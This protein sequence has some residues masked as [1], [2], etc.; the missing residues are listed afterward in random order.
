[1]LPCLRRKNAL[2]EW[3]SNCASCCNVL[4]GTL[5]DQMTTLA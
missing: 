1:M 4:K 5:V 2:S 3:M